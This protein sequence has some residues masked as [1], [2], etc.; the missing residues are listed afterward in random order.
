MSEPHFLTVDDY[1]P[2]ARERLP[3]DAYDYY[4]G[5]AGDEWTLRENRRA[6]DDWVIRPRML[7]GAYPPELAT[8]VLGAE[9]SM[10]I[11]VAPWAYQ[12]MAHPDGELATARA[13][14]RAGTV[15]CVSSTTFDYLEDV[16]GA[17]DAP[18]WW[19]LYV[20]TDR[21]FSEDVLHRVHAAGYSA[22]C[23]TVDFPVGGLRHRDTR[24]AFLMPIGLPEDDQV[25]D[26]MISWADV[27]W[28][29]E[30]APVPI[31]VK[32]VMTAEDARLAV[33][34]GADGIVVS[35]HGAR[36]LDAVAAT[37]TVLPEIVE[38]VE[39]RVPVIVD[40]GFRRGTDV[41]KALALGA[42]AVMVARPICW[43]LAVAGEQGV[44]DVLTILRDELENAMALAGVK[45]VADIGP[46][47]VRRRS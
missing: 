13:A 8:T 27:A 26:P 47:F 11:L 24:N 44:V 7:T 30:H 18:K 22:I 9:L 1:E 16:A 38:A 35:N 42:D 21:G 29:R 40:G 5:G 39:G 12:R 28:I 14:A 2:M 10:P 20:F 6:F 46:A 19:Q 31:L 33:E 45:R 37:I 41:F 36:Q 15:M 32:G 43:G 3:R 17:S 4:A 25:F 23:F 34:Y